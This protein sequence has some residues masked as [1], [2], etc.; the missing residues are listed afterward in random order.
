MTSDEREFGKEFQCQDCRGGDETGEGRGEEGR[1]GDDAC[2]GQG[3]E[4]CGKD[5]AGG[6]GQ[7]GEG[8]G[9][10]ETGRKLCTERTNSN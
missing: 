4:G 8:H 6:R 3:E 7:G 9:R 5:E 2:E 10:E 1:E